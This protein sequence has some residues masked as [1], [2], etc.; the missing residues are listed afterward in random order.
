MNILSKFNIFMEDK[1]DIFVYNTLTRAFLKLGKDVGNSLKNGD[2]SQINDN[3]LMCLSE[4]GII[5]NE[6]NDEWDKYESQI[7]QVTNENKMHIFLSMTSFCNLNCPYCYEDCRKKIKN[8]SYIDKDNIDKI[9]KYI[10]CTN[11]ESIKIAYFGG[12]PTINPEGLIYAIK[13]I[14]EFENNIPVHHTLITNGYEL[15]PMI[16]RELLRHDNFD[17]QIT[18]DGDKDKHDMTRQTFD[19]KGSFDEIFSNIL[20]L[21]EIIP[22]KVVIR[23]NVSGKL[24][25]YYKL[26]D[27]IVDKGLAKNVFL[28]YVSIFDGQLRCNQGADESIIKLYEYAKKRGCNVIYQIEMAPCIAVCK[29]GMAIDE[30]LNVY[31]CPGELYQVPIGH[32]D[33]NGHYIYEHNISNNYKRKYSCE[34]ECIYGPLCL[35][36]CVMDRKCRKKEFDEN[37][38]FFLKQKIDK[39][40]GLYEFSC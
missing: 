6:N 25:S 5:F 17:V 14:G 37:I 8:K 40:R 20:E 4:Q 16:V 21:T 36:G 15:S 1:G 26:T 24:D 34:K 39:F 11:P 18:L 19:K 27:K 10:E 29:N 13:R 3:L 23:I 31:A 9:I 7:T 35:G 30:N 2:L 28:T 38:P 33:E 12:E 32:I 22:N